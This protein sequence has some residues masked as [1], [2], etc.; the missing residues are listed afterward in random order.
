M[1]AP[2]VDVTGERCA[3]CNA[4]I[5]DQ[6]TRCPSCGR[7]FCGDCAADDPEMADAGCAECR[8]ARAEADRQ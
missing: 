7:Q 3:R 2:G 4:K 5:G 8:A 6:A 1:L